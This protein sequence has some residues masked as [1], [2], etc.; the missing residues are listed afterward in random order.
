MKRRKHF[1][2][3]R[4]TLHSLNTLYSQIDYYNFYFWSKFLF[5]VWTTYGSMGVML[6][7]MTVS[8]KTQTA[9][10]L[11]ELYGLAFCL[12][13]ILIIFSMAASVNYNAHKHYKSLNYLAVELIKINKNRKARISVLIK[14]FC[15]TYNFYRNYFNNSDQ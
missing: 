15:I 7:Y 6:L 10:I 5:I 11:V 8:T 1:S 3:I 9:M 14:V 13:L 2:R 4:A 12:G